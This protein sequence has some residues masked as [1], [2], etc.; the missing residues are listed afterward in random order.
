MTWF[1]QKGEKESESNWYKLK[2]TPC[3]DYQIKYN[4]KKKIIFHSKKMIHW[5]YKNKFQ[6]EDYLLQTIFFVNF[7]GDK[8]IL[9]KKIY[10]GFDERRKKKEWIRKKIPRGIVST[11]KKTTEEFQ[12]CKNWGG[13]RI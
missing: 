4:K 3:N 2:R 13:W 6:K 12:S 7:T 9:E 8:F 1:K 11:K 10:Y 5:K